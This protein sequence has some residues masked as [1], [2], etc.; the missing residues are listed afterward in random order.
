M[1]P[2][3]QFWMTQMTCHLNTAAQDLE[4]VAYKYSPESL[5]SVIN[6]LGS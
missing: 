2:E 1:V 3:S 6:P 5:V 4:M